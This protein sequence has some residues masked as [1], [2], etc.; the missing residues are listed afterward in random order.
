MV[1]KGDNDSRKFFYLYENVVK[2]GIPDAAKTQKIVAM[3]FVLMKLQSRLQRM[4][5]LVLLSP[6]NVKCN[7]SKDKNDHLAHSKEV[8]EPVDV[9]GLRL[10]IKNCSIMLPEVDLLRHMADLNGMHAE[11]EKVDKI[12]NAVSPTTKH[13]FRYFLGLAPYYRNFILRFDAI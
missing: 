5:D 3:Q 11:D 13:E 7:F 10:W 8:F 12:K 9:N 1:F 2:R 6:E 4:K